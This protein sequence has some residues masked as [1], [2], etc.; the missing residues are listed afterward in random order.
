MINWL[1]LFAFKFKKKVLASKFYFPDLIIFLS[2]FFNVI[3]YFSA[4]IIQPLRFIL[5]FIFLTVFCG[6]LVYLISEEIYVI[7]ILQ[8][9]NWTVTEQN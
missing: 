3:L 8:I 5:A 4:A 6:K 9:Q 7:L 2:I 1:A